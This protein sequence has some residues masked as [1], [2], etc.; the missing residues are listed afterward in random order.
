MVVLL[1]SSCG[2]A[3]QLGIIVI[4]TIVNAPL[5]L[6]CIAP[7]SRYQHVNRAVLSHGWINHQP[8]LIWLNQ[9]YTIAIRPSSCWHVVSY[10]LPRLM[11][12]SSSHL[13]SSRPLPAIC[14][15]LRRTLAIRTVRPVVATR[16]QLQVVI[17][18]YACM[19][20]WMDRHVEETA[21]KGLW[22][23]YNVCSAYLH[24]QGPWSKWWQ[25]ARQGS[26]AALSSMMREYRPMTG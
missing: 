10:C 12:L 7:V 5:S 8:S 6:Q 15:R 26:P 17:I 1:D 13:S 19:H 22:W 14:T 4:A 20:G 21:S 9:S 24:T 23:D 25:P 3:S 16:T 2:F 18:V 11:P